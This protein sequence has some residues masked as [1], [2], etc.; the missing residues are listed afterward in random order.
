MPHNS[1]TS[2]QFHT[3]KYL[4]FQTNYSHFTHYPKIARNRTT[5]ESTAIIDQWNTVHMAHMDIHFSHS[6]NGVAALH[7]QNKQIASIATKIQTVMF[8]HWKRTVMHLCV[9]A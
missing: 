1:P 5:D 7:S 4:F 3:L 2:F 9:T 8:V 6:V